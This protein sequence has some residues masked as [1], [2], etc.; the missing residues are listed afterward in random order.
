MGI[1]RK[2]AHGKKPS[3]ISNDGNAD[4]SKGSDKGM[5]MDNNMG[6]NMGSNMDSKGRHNNISLLERCD[7]P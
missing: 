7:I 6:S 4:S 1:P 5:D 3:I 2:L